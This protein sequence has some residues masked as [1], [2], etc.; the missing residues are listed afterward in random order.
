M[1]PTISTVLGGGDGVVAAGVSDGSDG[2]KGKFAGGSTAAG[3]FLLFAQK[4]VTKEKGT[5]PHRP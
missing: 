2:L 5:L 3:N 4:K 1:R